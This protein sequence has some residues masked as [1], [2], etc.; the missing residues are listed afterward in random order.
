M[1]FEYK[2]PTAYTT[3]SGTAFTNPGQAYDG[4]EGDEAT[5]ANLLNAADG[6]ARWHTWAAKGE[7]YTS[8]NLYVKWGTDG[9]FSNDEFAIE[10][11]KDGGS[12]WDLV[13]LANA[14]HNDVGVNQASVALNANQN[15]TQVEVRV[16]SNR[17]AG[18][19]GAN[20][21]IYD[22]WTAGEYTPGAGGKKRNIS[23]MYYY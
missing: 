11:T 7:T 16:N 18:G 10:A 2:K 14:V 13:L 8:T 5:N 9:G 6:I 15:L 19:D 17:V 12:N 20:V 1:A 21:Y 4:N 22:I 3:D 23:L